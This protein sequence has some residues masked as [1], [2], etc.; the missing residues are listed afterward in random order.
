M[1]RVWN[2][3]VA[4]N[5]LELFGSL[6]FKKTDRTPGPKGNYSNYIGCTD[7]RQLLQQPRRMLNTDRLATQLK[8][9]EFQMIVTWEHQFNTCRIPQIISSFDCSLVTSLFFFILDIALNF[10]FSSLRMKGG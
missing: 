9:S 7:S 4:R 10:F 6:L 8:S 2:I 1:K 5:F 3:Q